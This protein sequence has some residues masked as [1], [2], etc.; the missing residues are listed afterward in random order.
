MDMAELGA[1]GGHGDLDQ[2]HELEVGDTSLVGQLIVLCATKLHG[3]PQLH[4]SVM[5][6]LTSIINGKVQSI[7]LDGL[8]LTDDADAEDD[9]VNVDELPL[10]RLVPALSKLVANSKQKEGQQQDVFA[11]RRPS[12]TTA[13]TDGL[14]KHIVCNP[15]MSLEGSKLIQIAD[16][17]LLKTLVILRALRSGQCVQ[18][19]RCSSMHR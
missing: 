1:G 3:Q 10:D 6:M 9:F 16:V 13:R 2:R 19:E 18:A 11:G 4:A 15:E 12:A 7:S 8:G 5:E 17:S 14:P